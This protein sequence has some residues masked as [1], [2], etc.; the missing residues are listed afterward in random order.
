MDRRHMITLGVCAALAA[1]WLA[2]KPP[3]DRSADKPA[4]A[5]PAP[6]ALTPASAETAAPEPAPV[7]L[8][9]AASRGPDAKPPRQDG[10]IPQARYLDGG[11]GTAITLY[12]CIPRDGSPRHP[13]EH[14]SSETLEALAWGD[15]EA[16]RVLGMRLRERDEAAAMSLI[17]RASALS[18]GD[19]VPVIAYANAY[20][21]PTE[22]DGVPVRR[23]VHAKFVLSAV[24]DLLG[25]GN[26][27]LPHWEALIRQASTDP[28]R[29]IG[30]LMRRAGAIVE[31]MK[32]IELEVT[33]RSTIGAKGGQANG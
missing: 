32:A 9:A 5:D 6:T 20:P 1:A 11:D 13:Y 4:A 12:D 21:E 24:A 3:A 2:W 16:A 28:D 33:G 10:C 15:A 25:A 7:D 30:L 17:F 27:G 14:Y 29:E 23:S 22:I 31:E 8:A 18:G 19:P 26:S